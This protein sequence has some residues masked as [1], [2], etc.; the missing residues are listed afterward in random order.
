MIKD[1]QSIL[2]EGQLTWDDDPS[3]EDED[4]WIQD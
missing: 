1:N 4:Q 2:D 3:I